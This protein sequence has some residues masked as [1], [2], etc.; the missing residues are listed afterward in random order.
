MAAAGFPD[1][2]LFGTAQSAHQ[3]EGGNTNSDWWQWEHQPGTPCREPSGDAC[4]FYH[5]YRQDVELVARLGFNAFRLGIEW[6]RIEP[7]EGEFSRAELD[8]YRRVLST[9]QEH[10]VKPIVTFHHYTLPRWLQDLGGFTCARYPALFER[11][12]HRAA[13][14]LGDLI[15]YACTINEPEGLGEGATSWGSTR[16]AARMT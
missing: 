11:F 8:H 3:V 2:F 1:A 13:A 7:A 14:A 15:A 9:C 10:G 12:C 5:R 4:D 6:A 16:P